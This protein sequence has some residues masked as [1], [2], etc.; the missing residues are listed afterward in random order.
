MRRQIVNKINGNSEIQVQVTI[1]QASYPHIANCTV[2]L[3]AITAA[4]SNAVAD[5]DVS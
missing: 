1:P 2:T 3:F 5:S 4:A